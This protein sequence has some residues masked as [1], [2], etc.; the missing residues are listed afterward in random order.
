MAEDLSFHKIWFKSVNNFVRYPGNKQTDRQGVSHYL[1]NLV[2]GGR[3]PKNSKFRTLILE[4]MKPP[5]LH[6]PFGMVLNTLNMSPC[7][8]AI[9]R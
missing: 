1:S 9:I 3:N 5:D 8:V 7:A 6:A 4:K 2:S